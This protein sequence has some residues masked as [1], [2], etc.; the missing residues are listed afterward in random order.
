MPRGKTERNINAYRANSMGIVVSNIS[1]YTVLNSLPPSFS[2]WIGLMVTRIACF[3]QYV[4]LTTSKFLTQ[5]SY[6]RGI[7]A[8]KFLLSVPKFR[9]WKSWIL[10]FNPMQKPIKKTYLVL[11][12][13]CREKIAPVPS[14]SSLV[15]GMLTLK[16]KN[17]AKTVNQYLH[18]RLCC[19]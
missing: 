16:A 2:C 4:T 8:E 1:C 10:N 14:I 7:S 3:L 19:S 15:T 17:A 6:I 9:A 18:N 12:V 5:T 11:T 13:H